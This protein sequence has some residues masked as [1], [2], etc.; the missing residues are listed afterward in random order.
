MVS[1]HIKKTAVILTIGLTLAIG[2]IN[3][4]TPTV[5]AQHQ[6][7][8]TLLRQG[9]RSN[10]ARDLQLQLQKLKYFNVNATGFYGP[11]TT[12]AVRNFQRDRGL[13]VDGIAGSQTLR[14]LEQMLSQ[15]DVK[16][17]Q[18]Q[19]KNL[20]YFSAN[21]TGYYGPITR[22]A[23]RAF[24]QDMGLTPDGVAGPK[25]IAAIQ[26]ATPRTSRGTAT[27]SNST[28]LMVPWSQA[29]KIFSNGTIATVT[30][31]ATG[32]QYRVKRITGHRHADVET[33]TAEDTAVMLRTYGGSWSWQRRAVIVN[34]NGVEMAAS[35]AGMPHAGRDDMP[36]GAVVD[37]RSGGFGRGVN[38]DK[39]K[40]N[41]MSGVVC[42]HFYQSRTHGSNR[43][44]PAHQ[45]MIR[46]AAASR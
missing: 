10:A 9:M 33:L 30:D 45:E 42:I 34:V 23:L 31:V 27:R 44:D 3:T 25:T 22:E 37:N 19:L 36:Y 46:R 17:L 24:Q 43:V 26:R 7:S 39:I 40:N 20:N 18:T 1:M 35:V 21:V 32:L 5:Y 13:R 15:N 16:I 28:N 14:A 41:N 38:L 8:Q 2:T 4:Y 11:I 12:E 6:V 29:D